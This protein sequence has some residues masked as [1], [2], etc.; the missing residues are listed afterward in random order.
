[1][2]ESVLVVIVGIEWSLR[3]GFM[4]AKVEDVM[5]AS[6]DGAEDGVPR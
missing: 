4:V 5:L 1:M 6:M 2:A 3:R